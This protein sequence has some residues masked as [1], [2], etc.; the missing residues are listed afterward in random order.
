[1]KESPIMNYAEWLSSWDAKHPLDL[2]YFDGKY[3]LAENMDGDHP[4]T[5]HVNGDPEYAWCTNTDTDSCC[6]HDRLDDMRGYLVPVDLRMWSITY[7]AGQRAAAAFQQWLDSQPQHLQTL[8]DISDVNPIKALEEMNEHMRIQDE[9]TRKQ[10]QTQNGHERRGAI[11]VGWVDTITVRE[12]YL[13]FAWAANM[14]HGHCKDI[15]GPHEI[16]YEF[17][18][19]GTDFNILDHCSWNQWRGIQNEL[20]DS[21]MWAERQDA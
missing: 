20:Y 13:L 9:W 1:M 14:A 11:R 5:V 8:T 2:P 3:A 4:C 15:P 16:G 10:R 18:K 21:L 12:A 19:P 7:R 6:Y 17:P